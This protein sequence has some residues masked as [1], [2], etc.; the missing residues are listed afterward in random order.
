MIAALSIALGA[1]SLAVDSAGR[2]VNGHPAEWAYVAGGAL[3]TGLSLRQ[4][5]GWW[6]KQLPFDP[7]VLVA[8][9][10]GIGL[11]FRWAYYLWSGLGTDPAAYRP[12]TLLTPFRTELP[13][14]AV[15]L[16]A[17]GLG[18]SRGWRPAVDRLGLTPPTFSQLFVALGVA[19]VFSASGIIANQLTYRLTPGA[20]YNI[21][22]VGY[23]TYFSLPIWGYWILAALAGLC[24]ESLFRGALQPRAGILITAIL[25]ATIHIQYGFTPILAMVFIHGIGYG[26]LRRYMSTTTSIMAH[27]SYDAFTFRWQYD[28]V[29]AGILVA[30]VIVSTLVRRR[31]SFTPRLQES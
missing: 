4:E 18:V 2:A 29:W 5:L 24:E 3:I 11:V 27:A 12:D 15:A 21:V 14:L 19:V 9:Q 31:F 20:Y 8:I 25:F 26:L 22:Q 16:A 7:V 28:L 6:R 23:L 30:V 10:L 1:V 17:V 13:I